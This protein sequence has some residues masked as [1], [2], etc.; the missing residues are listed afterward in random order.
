MCERDKYSWL[1]LLAS[2]KIHR[3]VIF[4][5]KQRRWCSFDWKL[6]RGMFN[7]GFHYM[8]NT[9]SRKTRHVTWPLEDPTVVS[10]TAR[11]LLYIKG[12]GVDPASTLTDEAAGDILSDECW[13]RTR[14]NSQRDWHT[15]GH[16]SDVINF[17][18]VSCYRSLP[19]Y[20][21]YSG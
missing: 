14:V 3:S 18:S 15:T 13:M 19:T 5:G 4:K 1:E 9:G 2:Y 7:G 16:Q 8:T 20:A 21:F 6:H 10:M 11:S 17:L 12:S